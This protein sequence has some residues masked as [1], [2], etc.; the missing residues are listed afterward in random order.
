MQT[1]THYL[2]RYRRN[3]DMGFPCVHLLPYMRTFIHPD[4]A[5]FVHFLTQITAKRAAEKCAALRF[6]LAITQRN[7]ISS[8]GKAATLAVQLYP[9]YDTWQSTEVKLLTLLAE[10]ICVVTPVGAQHG[11]LGQQSVPGAV[12]PFRD[13]SGN[14]E[15]LQAIL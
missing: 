12:G 11:T 2:T 1:H 5:V 10:I 13:P 8:D 14:A 4:C 15:V 6:P 3:Q 9:T 7:Q